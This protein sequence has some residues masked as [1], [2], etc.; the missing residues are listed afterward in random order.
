MTPLEHVRRLAPEATLS[1]FDGGQTL[2]LR[3]R[4]FTAEWGDPKGAIEQA[5][6]YLEGLDTYETMVTEDDPTSDFEGGPYE[7][8][9]A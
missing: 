1:T 8:T 4:S 7:E 2:R 9:Y 6:D 3:G 5:L